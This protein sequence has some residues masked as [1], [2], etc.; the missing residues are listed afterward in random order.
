MNLS[1]TLP[2]EV[3][4]ESAQASFKNGVITVRLPKSRAVQGR[5]LELRQE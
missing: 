4:P 1:L 3:D 5:V 2:T